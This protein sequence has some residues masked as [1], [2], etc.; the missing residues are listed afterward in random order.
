MTE[1]IK[2]VNAPCSGSCTYHF[3]GECVCSGDF[4]ICSGCPD[5]WCDGCYPIDP[6]DLVPR[7]SC[8]NHFKGGFFTLPSGER[9][10][11][12]PP[13]AE[14]DRD[15]MCPLCRGWLSSEQDFIDS[16]S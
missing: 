4:E 8:D 6:R 2:R 14:V 12:V 16:W 7:N 13:H 3:V 10:L 1:R 11:A 5:G 9:K 15:R